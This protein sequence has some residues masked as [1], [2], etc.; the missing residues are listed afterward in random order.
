M[1]KIS[2]YKKLKRLNKN[3]LIE[4]INYLNADQIC[5]LVLTTTKLRDYYF[6]IDII[7]N[8]KGFSGDQLEHIFI[9]S[10]SCSPNILL[11]DF[12]LNKINVNVNYH[13]NR[14]LYDILHQQRYDEVIKFLL[15]DKRFQDNETIKKMIY[16]SAYS[17]FNLFNYIVKN[18][19][20]IIDEEDYKL[21][22]ELCINGNFE[23]VKLFNNTS[24][25]PYNLNFNFE[26]DDNYDF[27]KEL[28]K[29]PKLKYYLLNESSLLNKKL[30]EE[31]FIKKILKIKM[32][33]DF[34]NF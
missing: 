12:F 8:Y 23:S 29:I 6:V 16:K 3:E 18:F 30:H 33:E 19:N 24:S 1:I 25:F 21:F 5:E 7:Q 4:K 15:N 14:I 20:Y 2:F 10:L 26:S 13:H 27:I 31:D 28:L 32:Q 34:E 9:S 11:A 17:S 22:C